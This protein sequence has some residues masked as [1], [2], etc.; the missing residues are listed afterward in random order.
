MDSVTSSDMLEAKLKTPRH[1]VIAFS[2][3]ISCIYQE[4]PQVTKKKKT[5]QIIQ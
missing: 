3:G 4:K 2:T 5:K 1:H